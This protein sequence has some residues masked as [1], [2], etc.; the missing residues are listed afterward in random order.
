MTR[1]LFVSNGHGEA[2][3]A[4]RIARDL[5][6]LLPAAQLDHLALV[7]ESRS[8]NMR[9][10]GPRRTMPSG[11]LVAMGNVRN[12]L[13]DVRAG[14]LQLMA[15]QRRFLRDARGGYDAAVA[16]G[17]A[18]ALG[19]TLNAAAPT[20]FVGTAKSVSVAPYGRYERRVLARAAVRFVRD[21]PT[22]QRLRDD[23][24]QVESGANVIVD[25]FA[26]EPGAPAIEATRN[27][28]PSLV[29]LPGSREDAYGDAS[30]LLDVVRA[31]F[32]RFPALGAVLSLAAGL[33]ASRFA[34][35]AARDGW[36]IG[37]ASD[38]VPFSLLHEGR[39]AVIGWSGALNTAFAGATV[40]LGQAGTANEG[41]A[42]RGLPV[43]AFSH[44][45]WGASRWY[46][47][48]Q[49]GLLGKALA[50]VPRRL[51]DAASAVAALL[52]DT[53]RRRMMSDVGR[54]RMGPPGASRRIAAAIARLVKERACVA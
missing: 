19:V 38:G 32:P 14:L 41:A 51:P 8:S 16:V 12:L 54:A 53:A 21:E 4:D 13:R 36:N 40:V 9:E 33:D 34:R 42:A 45:G 48:R 52:D 5:H 25:L 23:G 7:G 28:A 46:R 44:D 1:V 35:D 39:V 2:A 20:I 31:L 49:E 30:F 10:V 47:R 15:R 27:F 17:D 11:G 18:Y 26:P 6:A 22:A 43:V 24:L 3:I 50:V 29:L 37:A